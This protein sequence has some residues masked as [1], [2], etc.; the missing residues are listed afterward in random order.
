LPQE[1]SAGVIIFRKDGNE[2]FFLLLRAYTWGQWNFP[3]GNIESGENEK[4]AALREAR[5]ET[6]LNNFIIIEDFKEKIEYYYK[7]RGE[8]VHKEVIYFL[9]ETDETDIKLS[10]EHKGYTWLNFDQALNLV[11]FDNS[12]ELLKKAKK[13]IDQVK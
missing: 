1:K 7:K 2:T 9:A 4:E 11:S 3:K 5:E 13:I 6:G 8:T 10:F 12:R